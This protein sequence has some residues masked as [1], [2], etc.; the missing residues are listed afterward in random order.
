ME[1]AQINKVGKFC[2]WQGLL[3]LLLDLPPPLPWV[4][5]GRVP[6][7]SNGTR[8]TAGGRESVNN[9]KRACHKQKMPPHL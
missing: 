9:R 4:T 2:L 8:D 1:F 7:F 3:W 5:L 6:G